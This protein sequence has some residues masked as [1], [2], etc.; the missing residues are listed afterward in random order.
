M[1]NTFFTDSS[2]PPIYVVS[3]GKGIAGDTV[4]QSILIQFPNNKIPIIIVPDVL[5]EKKVDE[6]VAT[7]QKSNGVIVHTMVDP[8]VRKLLV[9]AC[10]VKGIRHFDLV[11]DLSNYLETLLHMTPISKPGLYRL[12]H[13]DY[14]QRIESIEFTVRH[15][16][17]QH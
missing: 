2:L 8:E 3:G 4:V 5:T 10:T 14:F 9:N 11:G 6:T 7:A 15:D 1:D 16:D 17:G 12:S 13:I